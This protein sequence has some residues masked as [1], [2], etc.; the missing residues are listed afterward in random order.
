MRRPVRTPRLRLT[1]AG[2]RALA[3]VQQVFDVEL[4]GVLRRRRP[5]R[6]KIS[7]EQIILPEPSS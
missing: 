6:G 4:V 1:P 3:I 2:A 7:A 5:A